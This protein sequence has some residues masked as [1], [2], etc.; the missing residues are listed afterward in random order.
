MERVEPG[1]AVRQ[2][3]LQQ[4]SPDSRCPGGVARW[5]HWWLPALDSLQHQHMLWHLH[6]HLQAQQRQLVAR[7]AAQEDQIYR[8]NQPIVLHIVGS[9]VGGV[10]LGDVQLQ[11]QLQLISGLRCQPQDVAGGG[12][13]L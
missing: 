1:D 6:L 11:A 3:E 9:T 12:I 5:V 8:S 4:R 2:V 7:R 13:Q 10:E